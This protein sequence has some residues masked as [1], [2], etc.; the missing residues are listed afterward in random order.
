MLR[1]APHLLIEKK[2]MKKTEKYLIFLSIKCTSIQTMGMSGRT[3][4][5]Y[6]VVRSGSSARSGACHLHRT[7]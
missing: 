4:I 1:I 7:I 2:N 3:S 5:M 6:S